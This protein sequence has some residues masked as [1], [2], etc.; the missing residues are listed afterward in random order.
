MLDAAKV[1]NGHEHFSVFALVPDAEHSQ[2]LD[3][4]EGV[5]VVDEGWQMHEAFGVRSEAMVVVRPD[6]YIAWR[7]LPIDLEGLRSWWSS[8]TGLTI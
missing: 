4:L 1:L 3:A 2:R 6:G 7:S 8:I 5:V